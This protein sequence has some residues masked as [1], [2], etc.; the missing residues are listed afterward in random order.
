M[1]RSYAEIS[2]MFP[3]GQCDVYG[4]PHYTTFEGIHFDFLENCTYILVEERTPRHHLRISV[5]N[6]YCEP[7]ASCAKSVTV[8]YR[9]NTAKL[10]VAKNKV[11]VG[12]Y[13]RVAVLLFV[14]TA[15]WYC[16]IC[17]RFM[18]GLC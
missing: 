12:L 4:D 13:D 1:N 7:L 2:L 6:Y 17:T 3:L 15:I 16:A 9:N 10:E 5:D 11:Q 8:K 14:H 18:F